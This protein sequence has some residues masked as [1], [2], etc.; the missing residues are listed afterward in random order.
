MSSFASRHMWDSSR[1]CALLSWVPNHR[2]I[3]MSVQLQVLC[4]DGAE[5]DCVQ[6]ST[7]RLLLGVFRK[8]GSSR[9]MADFLGV[10]AAIFLSGNDSIFQFSHTQC[11][12][13]ASLVSRKLL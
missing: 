10:A 7:E 12:Y 11:P 6:S 8:D 9:H 2:A 5:V 4:G 3:Q 13:L 1:G